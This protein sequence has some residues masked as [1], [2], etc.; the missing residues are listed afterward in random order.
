M[1]IIVFTDLDAT[2]LD[3]HTYRY[4]AAKP[5]LA[6]L[7][8]RAAHIVLV[9]S[10][11]R[12][13]MDPLHRLLEL[14]D[15]YIIENGGGIVVPSD[16]PLLS[17]VREQ[18]FASGELDENDS[19]VFP[20]G[21]TYERLVKGLKTIG[22]KVGVRLA[23]FSKLTAEEIASE[24]GLDLESAVRAKD[25]RFDEPF[26]ADE[27]VRRAETDIERAAQQL[28]LRVEKGGRFHHLIGHG[29]K[30]RAV[31]HLLDVY[32]E[33]GKDILSIGLGDSPN[34]F[35]FLR[36]MDRPVLTCG[37]DRDLDVPSELQRALRPEKGG[38][39]GWNTA[40]LKILA[41]L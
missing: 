30:G 35:S 40:V 34:D 28:G 9:S 24:T 26:R 39:A 19:V 41:E 1:R 8:A 11:T 3:E 29:G 10:K 14:S 25:R 13:E 36:L 18:E 33:L 38:P 22:E 16:S 37:A 15:P 21:A 4:D 20:L 2:L 31:A 6:Q 12:A 17:A 32:R 5:A 27:N 23:G 7:K